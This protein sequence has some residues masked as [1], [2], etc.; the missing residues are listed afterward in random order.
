MTSSSTFSIYQVNS[1][2]STN[3]DI[4][5]LAKQEAFKP[6]LLISDEQTK[7]KG[8]RDNTWLSP[9]DGGWYFSFYLPNLQITLNE[10]QKINWVVSTQLVFFLKEWGVK[11]PQI[12]W[13]NDIFTAN[14]KLGGI[15]I[16]NQTTHNTIKSSIVGVGLNV[17]NI[18]I[19]NSW[20]GTTCLKN[21]INSSTIILKDKVTNIHKI[22]SSVLE[23]LSKPLL[24]L[25]V[26]RQKVI[27]Y[28]FGIN[29]YFI[30]EYN[31]NQMKARVCDI[32][33]SGNLI[34]E[35]EGRQIAA[36]SGTLKWID[37]V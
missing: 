35:N 3:E 14:G 1:C 34:L 6:I 21:E 31:N 8:Q 16:E 2:E 24:N 29:R 19:E 33:T 22:A 27:K 10:V 36:S 17:E 30:F 32:S 26:L 15:L 7:G 5:I 11:N 12:K 13:P 9:M 20:K 18:K 37:E 4:K 25:E 23:Q 28:S